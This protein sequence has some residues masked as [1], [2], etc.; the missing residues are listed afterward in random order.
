MIGY[1]KDGVKNGKLKKFYAD[2]FI[3]TQIFL[4][5]RNVKAFSGRPPA[6]DYHE[7]TE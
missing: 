3:E 6:I 5:G 1:F 2:G 7:P 4:H